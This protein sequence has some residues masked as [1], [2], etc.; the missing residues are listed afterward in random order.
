MP[1]QIRMSDFEFLTLLV[2]GWRQR[3]GMQT[4]AEVLLDFRVCLPGTGRLK[5]GLRHGLR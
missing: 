5:A 1:M 3:A 2:L 4:M